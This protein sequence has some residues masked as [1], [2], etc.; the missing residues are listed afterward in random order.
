[1]ATSLVAGLQGSLFAGGFASIDFS[2]ASLFLSPSNWVAGL[3][4][5]FLFPLSEI[6][7]YIGGPS[8]K[9]LTRNRSS[10]GGLQY[11]CSHSEVMVPVY[12]IVNHWGVKCGIAP[13]SVKL[14]RVGTCLP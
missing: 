4:F 1:M 5:F 2:S 8:K 3:S 7:L 6:I 10:G 12:D 9:N 14:G 11:R 13:K